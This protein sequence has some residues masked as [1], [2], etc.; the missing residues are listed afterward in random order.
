[1]IPT[2]MKTSANGRKFIETWEGAALK[3][4]NDGTGVMTIG[5]GH[6]TAAGPPDVYPGMIITSDEADAILSTD[7]SAVE[8]N[9]NKLLTI[10]PVQNAFDALVSFDYNTGGLARSSLLSAVNRIALDET[11]KADF[12]LWDMG[13]GQVMQGLVK[14]RAAEF[15]LYSTG[16]IVGP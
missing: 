12:A 16:T 2:P 8:A 4:Y 7:L 14:R 11:I 15:V 10:Q 9:V 13:G 3:A 5:Y 1:M 6:T